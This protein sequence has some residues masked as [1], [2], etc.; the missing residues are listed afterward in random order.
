[1]RESTSTLMRWHKEGLVRDGKMRQPVDSLAWKHLDALEEEF[2]SD[3]RNVRLG[4][5]L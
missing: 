3:P 5:C 1:M 2:A 4:L